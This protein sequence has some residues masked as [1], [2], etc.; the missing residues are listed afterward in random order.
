MQ[1]G[2]VHE[3]INASSRPVYKLMELDP[4]MKIDTVVNVINKYTYAH[5][6]NV[7]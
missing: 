7:P 2:D 4:D 3:G 5:I 6:H 1:V